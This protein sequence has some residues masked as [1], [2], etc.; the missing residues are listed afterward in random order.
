[1]KK[2]RK[3]KQKITK[4]DLFE[5]FKELLLVFKSLKF[6]NSQNVNYFCDSGSGFQGNCR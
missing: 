5:K 3:K 6:S 1:M 2:I 4:I